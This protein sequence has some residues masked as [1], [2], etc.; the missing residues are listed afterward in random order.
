MSFHI[1]TMIDMKYCIHF[2]VNDAIY[3]PENTKS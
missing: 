1:Y 3:F 2:V